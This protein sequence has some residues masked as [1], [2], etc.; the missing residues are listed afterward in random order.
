M[1]ANFVVLSFYIPFYLTIDCKLRCTGLLIGP[2]GATQKQMQEMSGA[3]IVIRGRGSQKEGAPSTGHPDDEVKLE[4]DEGK[5]CVEISRGLLKV[6]R[7][8]SI[9][10]IRQER[11]GNEMEIRGKCYGGSKTCWSMPEWYLAGLCCNQIIS[12][13]SD[14]IVASNSLS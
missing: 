1:S 11:E 5:N 10:Y 13:S 8:A 4:L 9:N 12:H 7:A 6:L 14:I 2:R 3:K